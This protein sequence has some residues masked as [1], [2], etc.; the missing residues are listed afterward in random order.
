[1]PPLHA[2]K[3]PFAASLLSLLTGDSVSSQAR[4]WRIRLT[5]PSW[6]LEL[7]CHC[8]RRDLAQPS[9]S[10][11]TSTDTLPSFGDTTIRRLC[12]SIYQRGNLPRPVMHTDKTA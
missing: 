10:L 12:T 8:S 2:I 6:M 11:H 7:G 5:V 3:L 9:P 4:A 1:M